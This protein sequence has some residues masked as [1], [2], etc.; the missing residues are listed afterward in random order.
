MKERKKSTLRMLKGGRDEANLSGIGPGSFLW[1]KATNTRLMGVVGVKVCWKLESGDIFYQFFHLDSESYGIDA[2]ESL[3]NPNIYEVEYITMHMTGGLGGV[4]ETI[5]YNELIYLLKWF[6][7]LNI[8]E[9]EPLPEGSREFEKLLADSDTPC[10]TEGLMGRICEHVE[11]DAHCIHYFLMRIFGGDYAAAAFL[12][13]GI[14]EDNI[15]SNVYEGVLLRNEVSCKRK[16]KRGRLCHAES[17]VDTASGYMIVH[18][19]LNVVHSEDG[20][21]IRMAKKLEDMRVS[22][23]EAAFL[24]K[25][26]EYLAIYEIDSLEEFLMVFKIENPS[27]MNTIHEAGVLFTYFNKD[28]DHVKED[29]YYLNSDI[30]S[31]YFVTRADQLIVASFEQEKLEEAQEMLAGEAYGEMLVEDENLLME[32]PVFYEFVNSGEENIYEFFDLKG[33]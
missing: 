31:A 23:I 13:D 7:A 29:L 10:D 22:N 28:N 2:Y 16:S 27:M 6:Y 14:A 15:S 17:L 33:I 21:R 32:E 30:H 8:S 1:A 11:N 25:K 12:M 4:F 26:P 24:L 19:E 20:Y 9:D 18:S 5:Y 3:I